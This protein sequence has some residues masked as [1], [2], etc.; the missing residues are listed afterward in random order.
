MFKPIKLDAVV[1]FE[2]LSISPPVQPP[3]AP[4]FM[5]AHRAEKEEYKIKKKSSINYG[6]RTARNV[7]PQ[8]SIFIY[9]ALHRIRYIIN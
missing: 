3:R 2:M 5:A 9:P 4:F 6:C 8:G 1:S 7:F